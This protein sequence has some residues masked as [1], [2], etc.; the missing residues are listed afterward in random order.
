M[1]RSCFL[2]LAT[3][4]TTDKQNK[5]VRPC[6]TGSDP[7]Q[8]ALTL[9]VDLEKA[10]DRGTTNLSP[11]RS[12]SPNLCFELHSWVFFCR[13]LEQPPSVDPFNPKTNDEERI[14]FKYYIF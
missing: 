14:F 9:S 8:D 1:S 10:M 5:L 3:Y 11:S 6:P 13:R 7:G 4:A 2:D 12:S